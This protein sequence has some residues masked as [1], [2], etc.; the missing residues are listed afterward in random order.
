MSTAA[1]I[2][3]CCLG[4]R[5]AAYYVQPG[6]EVSCLL[7]AAWEYMSPAAYVLTGNEASCLLHAAWDRAYVLPENEVSCK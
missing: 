3:T 7:R 4:M 2:C 5:P 1:Y 6:N